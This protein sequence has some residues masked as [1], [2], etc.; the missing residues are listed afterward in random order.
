MTGSYSYANFSSKRFGLSY[1]K[2][3]LLVWWCLAEGNSA[4]VL[5]TFGFG[6]NSVYLKFR[7]LNI[8]KRNTLQHFQKHPTQVLSKSNQTVLKVLFNINVTATNRSQKI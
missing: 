1:N 5:N 8:L 2:K 4:T 7:F 6:I 3:G